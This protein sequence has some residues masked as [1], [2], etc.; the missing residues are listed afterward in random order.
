MAKRL[1][2]SSGT[3]VKTRARSL[4]IALSHGGKRRTVLQLMAAIRYK[5]NKK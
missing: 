2:P 1:P 5:T 4:G 3:Q